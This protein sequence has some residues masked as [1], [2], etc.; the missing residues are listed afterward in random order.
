MTQAPAIA[1]AHLVRHAND[2]AAF[3]SFLESYQANPAGVPH[4]L[5]V[6]FKGFPKAGIP[7]DYRMLLEGIPHRAF[8]L[9]DFG[10]DIRPY[11]A[12]AKSF[13]HEHFV[14]LNSYSRIL[15]PGWLEAL[16]SQ[17]T[18]PGVGLVGATGSHQSIL[19]DFLDLHAAALRPNL[20]AWKR[21][22]LAVLRG[23]R[24]M[25]TVRG[26]F[27]PFP[28]Y[29]IRTNAFMASR[30]VLNGLRGGMILRKWD[31]YRFESG[32]ES[33]TH[34]VINAGLLP[35]VVGRDGRGHRPDDWHEARTFWIGAQENLLVSD[36]QTRAYADGDASLQERLAFHA[37]RR[38][39]DGSGCRDVPLIFATR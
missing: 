7:A 38:S 23:A 13:P 16:Y 39:P 24:Y 37:W 27:P 4:E 28:N 32:A 15:V 2:P 26:R 22:I 18:R 6:I 29:H 10:F 8:F 20:I 19:T 33:M 21:W 30:R 17:A 35:L 5:I 31:A 25:T 36:N 14:F 12:V 34:Q 1:V 3:R 9:R 11:L